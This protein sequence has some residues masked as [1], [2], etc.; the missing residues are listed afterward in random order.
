MTAF[1]SIISSVSSQTSVIIL[2]AN[3]ALSV[4][5]MLPTVEFVDLSVFIETLLGSHVHF[6][7]GNYS[8]GKRIILL[9]T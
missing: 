9:L 2:N 8:Q 4:L 1:N 6:T 5:Q 3:D 7:P